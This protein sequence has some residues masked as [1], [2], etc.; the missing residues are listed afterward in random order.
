MNAD[1]DK[2]HNLADIRSQI[3]NAILI[4]LSIVAGPILLGSLLRI[5]SIGWQPVMILQIFLALA[6][7]AVTLARRH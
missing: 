5:Q 3:S 7:W 4:T 1:S 2:F 6:I